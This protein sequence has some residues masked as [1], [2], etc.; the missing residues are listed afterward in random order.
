MIGLLAVT[1][2]RVGEALSLNIGDIDFD[3]HMVHVRHGKFAKQ[4]V[5]PLHPTTVA[6]L[7]DYIRQRSDRWP[8]HDEAPLF[9]SNRGNRLSYTSTH[10]VFSRLVDH[11]GIVTATGHRARLHDFRHRFAVETLLGWYR[12]GDDVAAHLPILSTF[13]GHVKPSNTYRYLTASPELFGLVVD[14]LQQRGPRS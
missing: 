12:A 13:L 4:R 7:T 5:I 10:D 3:E 11:A 6:K 2:M 14:R 1:A 8:T 9:V